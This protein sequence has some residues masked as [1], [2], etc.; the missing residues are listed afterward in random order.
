MIFRNRREAGILLVGKLSSF[1]GTDAIVLGLPRGGVVVAAEV[2]RALRLPLDVLVVKK[3]GSPHNPELAIGAVAPD[4]VYI[5]EKD[6]K[7]SRQVKHL[8]R[9]Y[10]QGRHPLSVKG[11]TVIV[12]D[13]G[14]ATGATIRAAIAWLRKKK[15]QRIVVALPVAPYELIEKLE[16][17]SDATIVLETPEDF[18][19]VGQFYD[20]FE[21]VTDEDVVELL[22]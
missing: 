14:A 13:D 18:S 16:T 19:A 9:F 22:K 15:A 7:R 17:E 12:V 4:G 10:R 2:A 1:R 3:I 21:Q 5:G 8:M 11:K 20:N 6:E